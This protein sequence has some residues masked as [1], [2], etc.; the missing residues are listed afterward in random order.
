MFAKASTY[1]RSS[2]N[3]MY[4]HPRF[5]L[6][7][8]CGMLT[9]FYL[10]INDHKNTH[11]PTLLMCWCVGRWEN[12]HVSVVSL[13]FG[14]VLLKASVCKSE[15][16]P[17]DFLSPHCPLVTL[18]RKV[19]PCSCTS[20]FPSSFSLSFYHVSSYLCVLYLGFQYY[21]FIPFSFFLICLSYS[22]NCSAWKDSS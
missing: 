10:C 18:Q 6:A 3:G 8:E 15:T 5:H 9:F 12:G 14:L 7:L 13:L 22:A 20:P 4:L 1:C 21:F 11:K 16:A 19:C 2:W 17:V